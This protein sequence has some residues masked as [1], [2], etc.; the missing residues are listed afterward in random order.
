MHAEKQL[1]IQNANGYLLED[2]QLTFHSFSF[3]IAANFG[4]L[5]NSIL[6]VRTA[7]L[8]PLVKEF[9]HLYLRAFFLGVLAFELK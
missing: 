4:I 9:W 5:A 1:A 6:E 8:V 7:N 2:F 3:V